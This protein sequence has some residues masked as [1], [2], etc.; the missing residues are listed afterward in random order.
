MVIE[1][2]GV[3]TLPEPIRASRYPEHAVGSE[4]ELG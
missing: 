3:F 4:I 1:R 2:D